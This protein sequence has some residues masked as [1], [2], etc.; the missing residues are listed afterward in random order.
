MLKI[1][2]YFYYEVA[3]THMWRMDFSILIIW[4]SPFSFLGASGVIFYFYFIFF[5]EIHV[6]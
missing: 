1:L 2:F 4:M 5:D 3:L 6:S